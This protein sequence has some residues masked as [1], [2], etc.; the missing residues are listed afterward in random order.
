VRERPTTTGR[1]AR[2]GG[3]DEGVGDRATAVELMRAGP[4]RATT[5]V[6]RGAD[7]H[8]LHDY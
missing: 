4:G 5:I 1:V 8:Q 6:K 3:D 2:H 7:H